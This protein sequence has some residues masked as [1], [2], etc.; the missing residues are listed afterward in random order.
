V[1]SGSVAVG[2]VAVGR[3]QR[4]LIMKIVK[5]L[6]GTLDSP[7]TGANLSNALPLEDVSSGKTTK[8]RLALAR[9]ESKDSDSL[10]EPSE[11]TGDFP[12]DEMKDSRDTGTNPI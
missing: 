8:G 1:G 11:M 9:I 10:G 6:T 12:I 3:S 5:F 7:K 2:L 4:T